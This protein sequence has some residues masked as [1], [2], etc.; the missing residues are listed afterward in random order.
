L[1][2]AG[3][4]PGGEIWLTDG[5]VYKFVIETATGI[6]LGTYDNI[7]GVNSNFIN[8]TAQEEVQTATAGQTVFTLTT[9]N[10]APGTNSLTVYIDGV[11]QYVGDSYLETNSSTVT[12]TS[13][14]H[15]GGE[16]KFTTTIQTTTGAVDA[17]IVS[18]EPPFT[19]GVATNVEDKLAQYVSVKD[20]GA[21][22]DGITDDTAAV[23]AAIDYCL[24]NAPDA[25]STLM[26]NGVCR[27]GSSLKLDI[28]IDD[29]TNRL[30]IYGN[31]ER[32]GFYTNTNVNMF[33]SDFPGTTDPVS[34]NITF[35]NIVFETSS[36][37]NNSF[38][39][40]GGKFL[41]M[42]FVGCEFY[43]I[44]CLSTVI[45][46]QSYRFERCRV[47]STLDRFFE[48]A[49]M[50]DIH[51]QIDGKFCVTGFRTLS[52]IRGI[53]ES[54][55]TECV[56]EGNSGS[57]IECTGAN[58]LTVANNYIEFNSA[59]GCNF[60]LGLMPNNAIT[61][62]G[63]IFVQSPAQAADPNFYD[64]DWGLTVNGTSVGNYCNGKLHKGLSATDCVSIG[65]SF[66]GVID[67]PNVR[68]VNAVTRF[69][70][71]QDV[72]EDSANQ[73]NKS[74]AGNFGFGSPVESNT[75]VFVRGS[76]QTSAN[77][78]GA[79]TDSAGNVIMGFRNDRLIEVPALSNFAND[80]AAAA[81]GIPV[82]YLYR[83]GSVVQVRVT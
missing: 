50:Y 44:R 21:V 2:S 14:V 60:A 31:G 40:D 82:G 34:G 19:G 11:N 76:D 10:Y 79:F 16:V 36:N 15:V 65:D 74:A 49:G 56:W 80:A 55:F 37:T 43:N 59:M 23:Q 33:S 64:I 47:R 45:Y 68:T 42:Y 53:T 78:A 24:S 18:Y 29:S 5:L 83:N 30:I 77:A 8:Y 71:A 69:G 58:G 63:N 25:A 81:A 9:M 28:A 67:S 1:D 66:F 57:L 32:A 41:R 52:T 54:S 7:T 72:W 46:T 20:F 35:E 51:A 61:V 17:S 73:I 62:Q 13:G 39:L 48:C 3:R 22:C 12:F 6:L 75:R 70:L 38:V 26:I 27:L 4:V